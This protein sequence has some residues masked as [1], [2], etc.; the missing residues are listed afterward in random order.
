M[1][2]QAEGGSASWRDVIG[3]DSLY[4]YEPVWRRC[5]DLR[6][7]P[8]F[9]TGARGWGLRAS[10][11]NFVYNHIGHFATA[12]EAVCKALFLGGVTRRFP[13]LRIGFL[14]GGVGWA[15]QLFADLIGH[16]EKRNRR[17][18]EQ[19]DP[20]KL[21]R[22]ALI[23]F[24]RAYAGD[25][26]VALLERE[27]A[28][29]EVGVSASPDVG[30]LAELDDF[31]AC[32]IRDTHDFVRLFAEPFYFGC[33]PDDRINA[34]AFDRGCN[35]CGVRLNAMFGSDVGHF[36]VLDMGEV[37]PEAC[38]LLDRGLIAP[39][40]FSRF[41]FGNAVRFFGGSNPEFFAG[42]AVAEAAREVLAAAPGPA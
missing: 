13:E 34:W 23:D 11:S 27:G 26:V 22:G 36:D 15:C 42:T 6:L 8:L 33:E 18:L 31:A 40:D 38:E 37:L 5:A 32:G 16:W 21:D 19:F 9:H 28:A 4:D 1:P 30:G 29:L 25:D 12:G 20:G 3:I 2:R 39:D 24:A 35:P 7:S 41:V 10:P 14:E 17:A